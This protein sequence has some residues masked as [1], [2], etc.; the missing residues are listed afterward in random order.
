MMVEMVWHAYHGA[1]PAH[2]GAI[3]QTDFLVFLKKMSCPAHTRTKKWRWDILE[4][5][6]SVDVFWNMASLVGRISM[7]AASKKGG[8]YIERGT[9]TD[10]QPL[11]SYTIPSEQTNI[12]FNSC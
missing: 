6:T 5:E 12:S 8:T 11:P 10:W 4:K 7:L 1:G 9:A 3:Q 2:L